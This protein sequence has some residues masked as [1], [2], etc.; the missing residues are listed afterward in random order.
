MTLKILLRGKIT[1]SDDVF[2]S[3]GLNVGVSLADM[4]KEDEFDCIIDGPLDMTG[5]KFF[6][7]GDVWV[8]RDSEIELP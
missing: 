8:H 4:P 6:F 3:G 1:L 5:S 7:D 2:F